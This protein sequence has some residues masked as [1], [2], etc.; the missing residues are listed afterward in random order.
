LLTLPA[1]LLLL[2][3]EFSPL[4][5]K[6]VWE[7]AKVLLVGAI[8]APGKRT[9]TACLRVMGLSQERCFTNYHR[10]LNRARW[11]ALEASRILLQLL[12]ETF[13]PQGELVLGLD[14][15]IERRRGDQIK[16]KGIYRDPVRSSHS[17]FVKASGLR[18]L[19]CM[20]L[21]KVSWA[22]ALWGLPFLTALCPSERYH[23]ERGRTH[24]SLMERAWQIIQLVRR[25]LP[26]R[27]LI[28]VGDGSFAVLD[29][30]GCIS[31]M[32]Q[33]SL[34][35]RLRMDAELWDPAPK[36][37]PG[38]NGRPRV[39]GTRRPSPQQ[40]LES[41]QT[42]WA[43]LEVEDWY[44]GGKREVEIYTETC[45]WYKSGHEAVPIRWVLVRDPQGEFDP[46]AFLSTTLDHAPLQILTWFVRRW[47]MEVTFEESRAQLGIETQRQWSDLAI[48]RTTPALLGLFSLVTLM[49]DCLIKDQKSLVRTAAWYEK[50]LPTFVDA[51]ALVRRCLWGNCH[52]STSN[53][54][55]D[56]LKVPRTLLERLTDA[57][58]YAA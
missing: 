2:I 3:V 58:C 27:E 4:F 57:V 36:R 34:I 18:W 49:A 35:T 17:H 50:E 5:S 11:S 47:R 54:K 28:F 9:V 39:K 46:Q 53:Q 44:G 29:L 7:H 48:A 1:E 23:A 52:F 31:S 42:K 13:A 51:I 14:D 10:V 16:A 19:C 37:K 41:P 32:P 6:P 40:R 45:V 26:D 38:Q 55:S 8:L 24:R 22:E 15:T 12:V 33:T 43:K 30:L 25:W 20:L 21:V 56:V